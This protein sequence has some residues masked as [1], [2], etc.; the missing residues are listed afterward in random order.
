MKTPLQ[1]AKSSFGLVVP[2]DLATHPLFT[3]FDLDA[4]TLLRVQ[5]VTDDGVI[6]LEDADWTILPF[7]EEDLKPLEERLKHQW[8]KLVPTSQGG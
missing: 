5:S 6:Y 1:L 3:R 2:T 8:V 7:T 4:D